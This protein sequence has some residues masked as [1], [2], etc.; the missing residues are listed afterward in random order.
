MNGEQR[1]WA[2][3]LVLSALVAGGVTGCTVLQ[4][5]LYV[6]GGYCGG[7]LPGYGDVVWVKCQ[8]AK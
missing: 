2:L 6:E 4:N 5:R 3:V 7:V 8:G 1:L